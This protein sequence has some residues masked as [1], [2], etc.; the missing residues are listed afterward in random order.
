VTFSAPGFSAIF[1][2][3]TSTTDSTG[4]AR[5][6]VTLPKVVGTVTVTA[7]VGT[8]STSAQVV[9]LPGVGSTFVLLQPLPSSIPV[10]V[11]PASTLRVQIA[12]ASGNAI[13]QSGVEVTATGVVTPGNTPA[14]SVTATSDTNG[15][16]TFSLPA[17]VGAIGTATITL[18]A[19]GFTPLVTTPI[20]FVTG[21][22][23]KLHVVTQPSLVAQSGTPFTVQPIVQLLDVGKN[24]VALAGITVTAFVASGGGMLGGTTAVTTDAFG[25]A[26]FTDLSIT[27]S[28]G[29]RTLGFSS[30]SL[31]DALSN[32][33]KV[34]SNV[35]ALDSV[36]GFKVQSA[37]STTV[38]FNVFKVRLI[39]N[40]QQ[41]V[42]R[43]NVPITVRATAFATTTPNSPLAGTITRL[44]DTSGIATFDDIALNTAA[45][46]YALTAR[47]DSTVIAL[48][49]LHLVDS[50]TLFTGPASSI[51]V[52]TGARTIGASNATLGAGTITFQ[53]K[54]AL[55]STTP[56]RSYTVNLSTVG[57]CSIQ[58]SF[59]S[60]NTGFTS[61]ASV[62][63]D[64]GPG[65][66]GCIVSATT[67][68]VASPASAQIA[69]P[70]ANATHVWF[71]AAGNG[72]SAWEGASG[73]LPVPPMTAGS[74]PSS[75]SSDDAFIPFW[76]NQY[77]APQL[78]AVGPLAIRRLHVDSLAM[79]DL[80]GKSLIVAGDSTGGLRSVKANG[81]QIVNGQVLLYGNGALVTGG[82]FDRLTVGDTLTATTNFCASN[83]VSAL[84]RNVLVLNAL[85]VHCKLV[86]DSIV[87][88]GSVHSFSDAAQ[89][90]WIL[91]G[92]PS[93]TLHTASGIF[94][95]DSV[96]I[97]AGLVDVTGIATF[98][99]RL[100]MASGAT[101]QVASDA[102]FQGGGTLTNAQL[103]IGRNATF[104]GLSSLGYSLIGGSMAVAGNFTQIVSGLPNVFVASSD[105]LTLFN[106]S[107]SQQV[108]FANPAVSGFSQVQFANAGAGVQLGSDVSIG[109]GTSDPRAALLTGAKLFVG[110]GT[111]LSVLGNLLLG[112]TSALDIAGGA[113][114]LLTGGSCT[115]RTTNSATVSGSG[116][117][118]GSPIT[119]ATCTP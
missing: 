45:G 96:V 31:P 114:V 92:T 9:A 20:A 41:T 63:I 16:V 100:S 42:T 115:G 71:G 80:G 50:L 68:G 104:G 3:V 36:P 69:A 78:T 32:Q 17:Y 56:S 49:V 99:G 81:A 98:G 66:G 107:T 61:T 90:G 106:G 93:A 95:G 60:V 37:G 113:N 40:A 77:T 52:S 83:S 87:V 15:I 76:N 70:P 48:P 33:I 111:T 30:G 19:P 112:P 2:P 28:S 51:A 101:L 55:G 85:D 46:T 23:A 47:A 116:N 62:P 102:N 110:S 54:D 38:V 10:G 43:A 4:E 57:N 24:S 39:D 73:W 14:V 34:S 59:R 13:S 1:S 89:P 11:P 65:V 6:S 86:V 105:H 12:D 64:V 21:S 35:T 97:G 118:S 72:T 8:L 29:F 26:S 108:S 7:A 109:A 67:P 88:A 94:A 53:V 58:P 5:T 25:T 84:L 27:G 75:Q 119:A 82:V 74:W 91:L 44:T 103:I 22:P 18:T 79:V 117:V